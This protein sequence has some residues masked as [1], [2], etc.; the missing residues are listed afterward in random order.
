M[1]IEPIIAKRLVFMRRME[2]AFLLVF[3]WLA[4]VSG[5]YA[6]SSS[7]FTNNTNLSNG[8]LFAFPTGVPVN[9]ALPTISPTTTPQVG[10]VLTAAN[11]S[12]TNSPTSFTYQ[13]NISGVIGNFSVTGGKIIAPNGK[14]FIPRGVVFRFVSDLPTACPTSACS[15][16]VTAFPGI[17]YVRLFYAPSKMSFATLQTYIGYLTSM[18]IVVE[19]QDAA[20]GEASTNFCVLTGSALTTSTGLI[21]TYAA[22]YVNN[23][24]VWFASQNEPD[25]YNLGD[26]ST[27]CTGSG[28]YNLTPITTEQI[29]YYNAVRGAGNN[30]IFVIAASGN[31]LSEVFPSALLLSTRH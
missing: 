1:S 31:P 10:S 4:P 12:W 9:T 16:R 14:Q 15:P 29:A 24:Y 26:N 27:G 28:S 20:A 11:G 3:L 13:W 23:P 2:A 30:N 25:L 18:G 22:A 7:T 5:G 17:N 19:L 6:Q 21:A 8:Q